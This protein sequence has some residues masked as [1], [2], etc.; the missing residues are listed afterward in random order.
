[1]RRWL[2]IP[3]LLFILAALPALVLAQAE[4]TEPPVSGELATMQAVSDETARNAE[5]A[6]RYAE[7][8]SSYLGIFESVGVAIGVF[9]GIVIPVLAGIFGLFGITQLFSARSELR[10]KTEELQSNFNSLKSE[11]QTDLTSQLDAKQRELDQ[12]RGSLEQQLDAKQRELDRLKEE[13]QANAADE[14]K[15]SENATLALSLLPLGE[16]QYQSKDMTGAID[17]Y[18][19]ALSLDPNNVVIH[20]RLG[21]VYT[22]M[23]KDYWPTAEEHLRHALEIDSQFAQARAAL[24]YVIRLQAEIL[25]KEDPQRNLLLTDAEHEMLTALNQSPKLVDE[26]G[27]SWWGSLGGLQRRRGQLEDAKVSY[28]KAVKV[29]PLSSYPVGLLALLALQTGDRD[30]MAS[31]YKRMMMLSQRR[32]FTH[33]DD[34][35]TWADLLVAQTA[36]GQ[37][38]DANK[39]LSLF[40]DTAPRDN[41]RMMN[42]PK[43]T[44][45]DLRDMATTDEDRDEIST[46][47]GRI[48][49]E[50]SLRTQG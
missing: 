20:Y 35:W 41:P 12:L 37:Y 46:I 16:R 36:M 11:L 27:Q 10:Q 28:A 24:G 29:T 17:A 44:L 45:I 21:Y 42:T 14:R 18:K 48:D 23:D 34:F 15:K 43:A 30:T 49:S 33:G 22:Q 4:T 2:I 40:F 5:E 8:A 47:I 19:R 1:M 50:I 13:V 39:T 3:L 6:R 7:D 32:T 38:E 26:D 31:S 9:T 25:P